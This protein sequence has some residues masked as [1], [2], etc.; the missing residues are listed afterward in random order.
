MNTQQEIRQ[1]FADY[2]R[3]QFGR[4]P[5]DSNAPVHPRERGRF[6]RHADGKVEEP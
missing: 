3:T 4:W 6:A 2:Q 5:F 1:A